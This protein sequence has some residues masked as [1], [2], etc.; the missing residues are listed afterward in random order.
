VSALWR[1]FKVS[2]SYLW[3]AREEDREYTAKGLAKSRQL[4]S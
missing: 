2:K 1:S 3:L 4:K